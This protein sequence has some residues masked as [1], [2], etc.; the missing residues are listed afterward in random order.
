MLLL[1]KETKECEMIRFF[2]LFGCI[3]SGGGGGRLGVFRC[4]LKD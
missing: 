3:G 1:T 2:L 4:K